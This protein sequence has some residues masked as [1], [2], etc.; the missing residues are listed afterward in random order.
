MTRIPDLFVFS[1]V[2]A[3]LNRLFEEALAPAT[4][5]GALEP[6]MDVVETEEAIV[7]HAEVAGLEPEELSVAVEGDLVIVSGR[8]SPARVD[9]A[10]ARYLCMERRRGAF[11]RAVR[12]EQAVNSHDGHARL[13]QGLLTVVLPRIT[14][15]R[16]RRR[17]LPI[18][19][20]SETESDE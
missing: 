14:D 17:P 5:G 4:E 8:R 6:R 20:T 2:Q 10:G 12:I 3:E 15:Q 16:R 13:E 18:E 9:D 19:H 1:Q 11:S 7:I